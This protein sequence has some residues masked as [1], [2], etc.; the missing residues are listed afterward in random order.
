MSTGSKF[1]GGPRTLVGLPDGLVWVVVYSSSVFRLTPA[2]SGRGQIAHSDQVVGGQGEGKHP[3]HPSDP[4]MTCLAQA[5]DGFEPAEDLL[6]ALAFLLTDHIARM[7]RGAVI[8]DT[9]LLARDMGSYPVIAQLLHQVL[10]VVAL[11]GT[12]GDAVLAR[13]LLHHRQ[14]GLWFGAAFG[15]GQAAVDRDAV[16]VL[17]QHMARVAE[18][19]LLAGA[20]ACQSCV[21]VG[22]RLVRGIA[23]PLPVEVNGG[24][25]RVIGRLLVRPILTFE[26][27]VTGPRLDQSAV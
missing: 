18:L 15:Q 7:A 8:D 17:H 27:L 3:A 20:L 14:R 5:C 19:G 10:A 1:S 11:V 2:Q 23:A 12:Q 13:N 6:N 25:A 21:G 4:A 24:I 16:A 9:G 22:G 26:A